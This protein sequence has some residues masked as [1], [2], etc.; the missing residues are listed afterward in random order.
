MLIRSLAWLCLV[1]LLIG[2]AGCGRSR[3]AVEVVDLDKVLTAFDASL[4]IADGGAESKGT[5][6][7]AD[8]VGAIPLEQQ[9][10]VKTTKFLQVF[11]DALNEARIISQPIGVSMAASGSINGFADL[12]QNM[13]R[14]SRDRELFT[15]EFDQQRNRLIASTTVEGDTYHRDRHYRPGFGGLFMGYM[16]VSMLGRHNSYYSSPGRAAP[17]HAAKRM[18]PTNYR[19]SAISKSS[20]KAAARRARSRGG[21]GGFRGGK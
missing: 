11:S 12:N 21:S 5:G 4:K 14:D 13:K 7:E 19:S 18:S 20:N 15:I 17:N 16:L 10:V 2:V 9:D 1:V 6:G 3:P 8:G